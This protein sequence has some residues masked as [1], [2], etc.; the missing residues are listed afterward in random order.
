MADVNIGDFLSE[1]SIIYPESLPQDFI[2]AKKDSNIQ[3]EAI[4]FISYNQGAN[5]SLISINEIINFEFVDINGDE[6]VASND[7]DGNIYFLK[8]FNNIEEIINQKLSTEK[9]KI[10]LTKFKIEL[11]ELSYYLELNAK[12]FKDSISD[13]VDIVQ[14]K[15]I[16]FLETKETEIDIAGIFIVLAV[17]VFFEFGVGGIMITGAL[18]GL[19]NVAAKSVNSN[20]IGGLIA[21]MSNTIFGLLGKFTKNTSTT[22]DLL[23]LK[24]ALKKLKDEQKFIMM[25]QKGLPDLTSPVHSNLTKAD[26][27]P[28]EIRLNKA[29]DKNIKDQDKFLVDMDQLTKELIENGKSQVDKLAKALNS[30]TAKDASNEGAKVIKSGNEPISQ[31]TPTHASIANIP[32]DVYFKT[33]IS[34]YVDEQI[35][36][37]NDI[38]H[39]VNNLLM[40]VGMVNGIDAKMA[41]NHQDI[42]NKLPLLADLQNET[43]QY[44]KDYDDPLF[45]LTNRKVII[46]SELEFLIW[47]FI[48]SG[49]IT[50][51][52]NLSINEGFDNTFI[53]SLI[54]ENIADAEF[55][56]IKDKNLQKYLEKR[57]GQSFLDIAKN[58]KELMTRIDNRSNVINNLL[59]GS[60]EYSIQYLVS[61]KP[62]QNTDGH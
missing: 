54:V 16:E 18:K 34:N 6:Y 10:Y 2:F 13:A 35:L 27:R 25:S 33:Y 39:L 40:N 49:G 42:I 4:D 56:E 5:D 48:I 14:S 29:L 11:D 41:N 36:V 9:Y 15:R 30:N 51:S 37:V 32:I 31:I 3:F 58:M 7:S 53:V 44:R 17:A 22:G 62:K 23:V 26:L 28:I 50:F 21:K 38:K 45:S 57:F 52:K 19:S 47:S 61:K 8:K 1:L 24:N 20:S 46:T 43:V 59:K 55:A 60:K 12:I